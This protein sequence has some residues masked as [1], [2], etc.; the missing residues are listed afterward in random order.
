MA[1]TE[2]DHAAGDRLRSDIESWL[3][4]ADPGLA[5]VH[6]RPANPG[7]RDRRRSHRDPARWITAMVRCRR[8]RDVA[9]IAIFHRGFE[10]SDRF[11]SSRWSG[12]AGRPY[13]RNGRSVWSMS[14]SAAGCGVARRRRTYPLPCSR[15]MFSYCRM[16]ML[17]AMSRRR[18]S[19]GWRATADKRLRL[20]SPARCRSFPAVPQDTIGG[21]VE[22][23]TDDRRPAVA[24]EAT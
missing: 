16:A 17:T 10:A 20:S 6:P 24:G 18:R 4:A 11:H 2:L 9:A 23:L 3:P 15:R 13:G 21:M 19:A 14:Y 12:R 1:N 8:V 7:R 5:A 22:D